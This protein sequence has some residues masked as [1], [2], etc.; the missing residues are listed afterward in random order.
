[1]KDNVF[2]GA[3][4]DAKNSFYIYDNRYSDVTF[5]GE[6]DFYSNTLRI[7]K[8]GTMDTGKIIY[9]SKKYRAYPEAIADKMYIMTNDNAP[10]FKLLIGDTKNPDSKNW[11]VLIPESTTVMEDYSV[12]KAQYY[13]S[14]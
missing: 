7:K 13:C 3:P 2:L 5:F 12:T 10:N 1:M 11:K 6:S 14:G 4:K 9:S 8:T